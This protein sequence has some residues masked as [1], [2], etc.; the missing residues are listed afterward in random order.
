MRQG[1]TANIDAIMSMKIEVILHSMKFRNYYDIYCILLEGYS[2]HN[3][4]QKA[5]NLSRHRLSSKNI[6]AMPGYLVVS[7][8]QIT[9]SQHW[10]QNII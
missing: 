1:L 4:I 8:V 2:I 7:L 10:N 3:C 9:I 5:L 6:I